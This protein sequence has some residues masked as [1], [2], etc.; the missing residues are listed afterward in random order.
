MNTQNVNLF[1]LKPPRKPEPHECCGT[2]CIPCVMDIYEEELWEYERSLK[3]WQAN[4][5]SE[6]DAK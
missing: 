2:G 5:S 4:N 1:P 3:Q 6:S